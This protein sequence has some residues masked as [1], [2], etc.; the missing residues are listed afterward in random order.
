MSLLPLI[1]LELQHLGTFTTILILITPRSYES[2]HS[3]SSITSPK[4]LSFP[5][6]FNQYFRVAFD[7]SQYSPADLVT[8]QKPS[9]PPTATT[10]TK[11]KP[12][13]EVDGCD[14][15][16]ANAYC[17]LIVVIEACPQE[18]STA[19][20]GATNPPYAQSQATFVTFSGVAEGIYEPKVLK[21]TLNVC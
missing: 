11:G 9:E 2:K 10:T 3:L 20:G 18:D 15:K 12:G 6:K 19:D 1:H 21:Q 13:P 4:S 14:R 16:E 7:P 5:R 8:Y 17:P